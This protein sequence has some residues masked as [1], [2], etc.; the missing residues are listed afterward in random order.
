MLPVLQSAGHSIMTPPKMDT[1][2]VTEQQCGYPMP[3]LYNQYYV[4]EYAF[5]KGLQSYKK[6]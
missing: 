1:S 6:S 3:E 5:P 2:A 4:N